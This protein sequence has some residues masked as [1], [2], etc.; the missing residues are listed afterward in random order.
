[1]KKGIEEIWIGGV[2]GW[3]S[4]WLYSNSVAHIRV[5]TK[6]LDFLMSPCTARSQWSSGGKETAWKRRHGV[7]VPFFI[8]YCWDTQ[9]SGAFLFCTD[10]LCWDEQNSQDVGIPTLRY[11]LLLDLTY[12]ARYLEHHS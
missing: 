3:N 1:V 7:L 5:N 8:K 4:G 2:V 11:W 12:G 10:A 6:V 9:E